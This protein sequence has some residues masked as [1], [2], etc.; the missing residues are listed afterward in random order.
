MAETRQDLRFY[1]QQSQISSPGRYEGLYADLPTDVGELCCLIQGLVVHQFWLLDEKNSGV[2]AASLMGRGRNLNDEINLRSIE[3]RIEVLLGL[4]DSPLTSPRRP[5]RR[6]VGNCRD[7]SLMLVSMLRHQGV[8]ARVRSGVARY[9]YP[10]EVRLEDHFVCEFWNQA[11]ER[12]QRTDA[13]IDEVQRRVLGTTIDMADLPPDQFL[14]AAESYV[15]LAAGKVEPDKIGIFEYVGWPYVRYKLLSDLACLCGVE[16]LAWEGW[17]MFGE[18]A[19]TLSQEDL[20]LL[21]YLVDVIGEINT[22]PGR[23]VEVRGLFETHP[24]L[25]MP[26]DY[27][28]HY[29]ELPFFKAEVDNA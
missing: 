17:G 16:V 29:F 5:D 28:P 11:E 8:P 10:D 4:D 24:R 7:Y 3:D 14:D 15:E 26:A 19:G 27:W 13:Q 18:D 12:W 9:F 22:D 2:T 1:R 21:A 6:V 20:A 23:F 25:R